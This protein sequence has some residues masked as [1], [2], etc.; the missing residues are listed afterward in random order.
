MRLSPDIVFY[1]ERLKSFD[2]SLAEIESG[3]I[4]KIKPG[5]MYFLWPCLRKSNTWINFQKQEVVR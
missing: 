5:S 4:G 2:W 1:E 3:Y